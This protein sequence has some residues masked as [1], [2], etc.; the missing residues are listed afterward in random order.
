MITKKPKKKV[1]VIHH[2]ALKHPILLTPTPLPP[3]PIILVP[4]HHE[5]PEQAIVEKVKKKH[6][7]WW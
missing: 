5:D 1:H 4:E 7:Y 2:P 6:W 3:E